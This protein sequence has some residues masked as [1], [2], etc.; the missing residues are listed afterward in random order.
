MEKRRI[1]LIE[2]HP[3]LSSEWH[4]SFNSNLRPSDFTAGS[5]KRIWW[6]CPRG[7]D[8]VW[9]VSIANRTKGNG[10]PICSNKKIVSSNCLET[11]RPDLAREWHPT[12]NGDLTPKMVSTH[13]SKTVWWTCEKGADHVYKTSI[14]HRSKGV[15]C[16]ACAGRTVVKSNSL[17]FKDPIH[18]KEWNQ[19]KN[20][21]LTPFDVTPKSSKK[22]WWKCLKDPEHEW[23][24]TVSNKTNGKGCPFCANRKITNSNSLLFTHPDLASQWHPSL[25][26]ILKPTDIT[27]GSHKLVWWQCNKNPEHVWKSASYSRIKS[28]NC[29][30]CTG[31]RVN[32]SNSLQSIKPNLS[33]E[34]HPFKNGNLRPADFSISS[35]K[36]VWWKCDNGPDH[37][38]KAIIASRTKG[39]GCPVCKGLKVVES[40]S[41]QTNHPELMPEWDYSRNTNLDPNKTFKSSKQKVWWKCIHNE[42]HIW[43][44]KISYRV[45]RGYNCPYCTLTP[46]SKEELTIAFEL[47]T[48]F[49]DIDPKG[50]K[51]SIGGKLRSVDI[52]IPEKNL[53]IEFDGSY[54]HKGKRE[55]DKIKSEGL[56][57]EGYKVIRVREEPLKKIHR[58][59]IISKKPYDGKQITNDILT[60]IVNLFDLDTELTTRIKDYQSLS[61]LQNE[62]GLNRYIDKILKEKAQ[63]SASN[64]SIEFGV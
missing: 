61:Q 14:A 39:V 51:V 29:P 48:I 28:P 19:E 23:L 36:A 45:Q 3:D 55:L 22:V 9:E 11:L 10:C 60:M 59:D 43:Q 13:S 32:S 25:N 30:F 35:G 53:C 21:G 26:Q 47:K 58:T 54:W 15:G 34:W 6:K 38:W 31:Q 57:R 7:D 40:N 12:L 44:T 62:N 8:H 18:I 2:T 17:A 33:K 52:Y 64:Q 42:K 49:K 46:Q 4:P 20:I 37:E 50:F 5:N 63:R 24:S 41:F 16:S 27:V 1:S 56:L